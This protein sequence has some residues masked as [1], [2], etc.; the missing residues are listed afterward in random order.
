MDKKLDKELNNKLCEEVK[1][2]ENNQ[3]QNKEDNEINEDVDNEIFYKSGNEIENSIVSE[4][5]D[6]TESNLEKSTTPEIIETNFLEKGIFYIK[7]GMKKISYKLLYSLLISLESNKKRENKYHWEND[8]KI[9]FTL[10]LISY[11]STNGF[12]FKID[13]SMKLKIIEKKNIF[14]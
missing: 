3:I 11:D 1:T 9:L 7:K 2:K 8:Q 6:T 12:I 4:M 13:D 10:K 5:D 14:L